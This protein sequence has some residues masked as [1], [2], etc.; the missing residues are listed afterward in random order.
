MADPRYPIGEFTHPG[1]LDPDRRRAG[2]ARVA[3]A[4]ALLRAAVAGLS[5]V[6][7]DT[8]YRPDGWTVRQVAHHVSDSHLNGYTRF[9]LALTTA[10]PTIKPY[11][12]G[13]WA[14]LPD[15]RT[16]PVD[17]SLDLLDALHRPWVLLLDRL[18]ADDWGRVYHHPDQG[19]DITL[20]EAL[21][22]YAWHGEHHTAHITAPRRRMGGMDRVETGAA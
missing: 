21:G 2:I 17:P 3:A 18:R 4:P 9:R 20:D 16:A 7:L 14:R 8:P 19:R 10:A 6:Q 11:D 5:A 15:A 22:L 13:K 1:P 12:E